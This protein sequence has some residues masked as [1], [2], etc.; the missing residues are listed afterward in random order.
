MFSICFIATQYKNSTVIL[1]L[2]P[3]KKRKHREMHEVGEHFD[4]P[5]QCL[6]LQLKTL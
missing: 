4:F 2:G 5:S 3:Q 6:V 1:M